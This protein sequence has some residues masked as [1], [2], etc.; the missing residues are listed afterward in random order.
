MTLD[1]GNTDKLAEFKRDADRLKI[2]IIAPCVNRSLRRLCCKKSCY[3]LFPLRRKRCRATS[4][5]A[6]G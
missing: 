4:G 1:M 5:G 2:D 6:F 3:S